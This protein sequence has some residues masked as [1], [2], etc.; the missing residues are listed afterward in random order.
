MDQ[1]AFCHKCLAAYSDLGK[2]ENISLP[3]FRQ[4]VDIKTV[5][6]TSSSI[7]LILIPLCQPV[8]WIL[9]NINTPF[10]T[11]DPTQY[12]STVPACLK[13]HLFQNVQQ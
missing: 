13:T 4:S 1:Y 6:K 5:V 3:C 7:H 2:E 9:Q 10:L 8:L 12:R 11:T